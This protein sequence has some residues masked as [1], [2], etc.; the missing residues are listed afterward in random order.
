VPEVFEGVITKPGLYPDIPEDKYHADPVPEGSLSHSGAKLL[1]P[2]SCPAI[3]DWQRQ[4]PKRSSKS[5]DLG[6]VV[7]SMVLGKGQDVRVLDFDDR[8][9][10]AYKEAEAAA[11]A[12]DCIPMLRKDYMQA[13]DIAQAVMGHDTAGALFAEGD[14]EVSMFWQDSEFGIWCRARSD[15]LTWI[16]GMPTIVDVKT[17]ADVSPE[18]WAKSAAD[19]AYHMQDPWYR[20]GLATL[21]GCEPADVDFIFAVVPTS[22]PYLPMLYRLHPLDVERGEEQGRQ[23]R[24]IYRDCSQTG[25][26]P[27]WTKGS[28]DITDLALPGYA[29]SRIDRSLNEFRGIITDYDF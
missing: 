13:E 11:L 12:A 16:D 6:T 14:A 8:R 2:P 25:V 18:H 17:T 3:Y 19:F 4:H 24:E 1:L 23:A 26:W 10:K 5:Q 15:W 28:G 7:H 9:T 22:P 21:L 20:R 29:R 27:D